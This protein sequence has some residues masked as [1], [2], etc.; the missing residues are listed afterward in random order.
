MLEATARIA[1]S[2]SSEAMARIA[3][4]G[5]IAPVANNKKIARFFGLDSKLFSKSQID[6]KRG[7]GSTGGS[8]PPVSHHQS[9]D[10]TILRSAQKKFLRNPL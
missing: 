1:L 7:F 8:T 10:P 2:Q 3:P 9:P 5:P 6:S 4:R